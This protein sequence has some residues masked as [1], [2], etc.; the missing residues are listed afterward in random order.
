MGHRCLSYMATYDMASTVYEALERG[1]VT[2]RRV[3]VGA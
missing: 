2:T 3:D 1:V